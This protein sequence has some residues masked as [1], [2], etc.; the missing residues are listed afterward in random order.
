MKRNKRNIFD[1]KKIHM[2][3]VL[4]LH[5]ACSIFFI[6]ASFILCRYNNMYNVYLL[7]QWPSRSR[8]LVLQLV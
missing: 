6:F 3:F 5:D 8:L 7:D 4:F 2:C 1:I